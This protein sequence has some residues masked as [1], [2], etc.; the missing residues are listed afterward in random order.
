MATLAE[1]TTAYLDNADYDATASVAKA[2]LFRTACRQLIV[3]LPAS[4]MRGTGGGNQQ[5]ISFSIGEVRRSLN[6]VEA[7]LSVNDSAN[8]ACVHPDFSCAR[9]DY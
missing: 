8:D 1:V 2:K 6:D 3:V 7:W 5:Q 4:T 9:G